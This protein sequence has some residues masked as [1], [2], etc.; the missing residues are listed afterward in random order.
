MPLSH[1]VLLLGAGGQVG[2]AL[3]ASALPLSWELIPATRAQMDLTNV[4]AL[5]NA[6]QNMA[7]NLIINAAA[8]TKV[9]QAQQDPDAAWLTNFQAVAQLAAQCSALDIPLIHLSTDYV[10]DGQLDRPYRETDKLNPINHYGASKLLG[11][12]AIRH[13]LAWHVII[14]VS[15][16]FSAYSQN[17]LTNTLNWIDTKD[18]LQMVTDQLSAPTPAVDVATT[19]I[20][21][22]GQILEGKVNGYGTFHYCGTPPC[23]RYDLTQAIMALYSAHATRRPSITPVLSD[24]F[25]HLAPR[26]AYS[27][28][29]CS[30]IREVYGITQPD[31]QP[32]LREAIEAI[33]A[34]RKAKG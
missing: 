13:E 29:D 12:E 2:Q 15:S 11:E 14:R 23:T 6:V 22:A 20:A 16:V 24:V 28:M 21:V 30:K 27:V 10:F 25:A 34:Q 26:P 8:L 1:R 5:R 33:I 9:D 7:P 3:Q 4:P 31:W 17:I 19:L 32:R 18:S